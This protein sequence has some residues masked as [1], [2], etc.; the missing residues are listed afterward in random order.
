[1]LRVDANADGRRA[2]WASPVAVPAK[3]ETVLVITHSSDG[4]QEEGRW[5]GAKEKAQ[6]PNTLRLSLAPGMCQTIG[7]L[8]PGG[9]RLIN[10]FSSQMAVGRIGSLD[11]EMTGP[12]PWGRRR[13]LT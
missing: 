2:H 4:G 3:L 9:G 7:T 8:G 5:L 6:P 11:C 12:S 13:M 1:M 10:E